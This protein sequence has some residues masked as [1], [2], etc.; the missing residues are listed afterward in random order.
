[1][2]ARKPELSAQPRA[3][4]IDRLQGYFAEHFAEPPSRFRANELLTF[5]GDQIGSCLYKQG[6]Q[7]ARGYPAE[8]LDDLDAQYILDGTL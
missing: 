1:M 7:N 6:I 5:V 3:H 2:V 8:K 4:I